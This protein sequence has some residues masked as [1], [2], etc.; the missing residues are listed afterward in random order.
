VHRHPQLLASGYTCREFPIVIPKSSTGAKL[1]RDLVI[2]GDPSIAAVV[3]TYDPPS[4][5]LH[6]MGAKIVQ[7]ASAF[8]AGRDTD[9]RYTV[10]PTQQAEYSENL[11][12]FFNDTYV[13]AVANV[14]L[15]ALCIVYFSGKLVRGGG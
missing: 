11:N 7:F 9:C 3:T 15:S 14:D 8:K 12:R 13:V 2:A 5:D 1:L 4:M 10:D 6:A